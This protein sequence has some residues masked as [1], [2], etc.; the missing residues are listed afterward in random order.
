MLA[1]A[2]LT[3]RF[4][5]HSVWC[6]SDP[7]TFIPLIGHEKAGKR[8]LLRLAGSTLEDSVASGE[9]WLRANPEGV[10]R[11]VLVYDALVTLP[12]GTK[13]DALLAHAV[14]YAE[15]ARSVE[16]LVPYVPGGTAAGFRVGSPKVRNRTNF[17]DADFEPFFAQFWASAKGHTDAAKV[18][19]KHLDDS[20]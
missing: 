7:E 9:S 13:R 14:E 17:T 4:V 20:L 16:I 12:V 10:D 6:V 19:A 5:A 8:G 2:D 18:W 3:G 1:L 15:G 11:A